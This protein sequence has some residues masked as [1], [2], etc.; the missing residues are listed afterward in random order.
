MLEGAPLAPGALWAGAVRL[1]AYNSSGADA[2]AFLDALQACAP[3]PRTNR[4]RR[5][6]HPVLI[7]HAAAATITTA[8]PAAPAFAALSRAAVPLRPGGGAFYGAPPHPPP[9]STVAPT[10]RPTVLSEGV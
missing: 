6:P 5:V 4:T 10:R 1:A 7:G 8:A 3:S 9:P 2:S